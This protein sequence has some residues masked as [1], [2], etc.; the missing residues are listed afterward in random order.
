[1][2]FE[3]HLC[4]NYQ[5][6]FKHL[7][8][9]ERIKKRHRTQQSP[10][11]PWDAALDGAVFL[12]FWGFS[13]ETLGRVEAFKHTLE[14]KVVNPLWDCSQ[15]FP[16]EPWC[17]RSLGTTSKSTDPDQISRCLFSCFF[18][19]FFSNQAQFLTYLLFVPLSDIC[20]LMCFYTHYF[21]SSFVC[22]LHEHPQLFSNESLS[23]RVDWSFHS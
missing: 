2:T 6:H 9:S 20:S 23:W 5:S 1:M 22:E 14:Y 10:S 8:V 17:H 3:I 18:V 19:C 16:H 13:N 12:L 15:E 11:S 21:M 4:D 7:R